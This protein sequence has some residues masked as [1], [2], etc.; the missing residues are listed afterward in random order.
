MLLWMAGPDIGPIQAAQILHDNQVANWIFVATALIA[1]VLI[2]P[3][4]VLLG[5]RLYPFRPALTLVGTTTFLLG[6]VLAAAATLA[7]LARFGGAVTGAMQSD[8]LWIALYHT[9]TALFVSLGFAGLAMMLVAGIILTAALWPYHRFS[10]IP[11]VV[12]AVAF[13]VALFLPSFYSTIGVVICLAI[14]AVG[15]GGLGYATADL[16]GYEEVTVEQAAAAAIGAKPA[17]TTRSRRARRSRRR[18]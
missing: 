17:T 4:A 3:I 7:S 10:A 15:W 12:A 13:I 6:L 2:A 16:E 5:T 8:A 1:F 14:F 18:R 9:F 11:L